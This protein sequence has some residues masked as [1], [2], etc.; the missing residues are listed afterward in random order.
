MDKAEAIKRANEK[1]K[2]SHD[3]A[4][5]DKVQTLLYNIETAS[6]QLRDAKRA[7]ADLEYVDYSVVEAV[8]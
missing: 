2:Q 8:G 3:N 7:L 4:F 5:E 6:N 1:A